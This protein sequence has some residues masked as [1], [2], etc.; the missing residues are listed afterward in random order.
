[1][2]RPYFS[3]IV[4]VYNKKEHLKKCLDSISN[5]SFKDFEIIIVDD[6]SNDGSDEIYSSFVWKQDVV[7]K[8]TENN[9][10]CI[11][12]NIGIS[13][14][15]GKWICFLDADDIYFSNHL[16]SHFDLIQRHS[17]YDIFATEQLIGGA[18]KPYINSKLNSELFELKLDDFIES[19]PISLNQVSINSKYIIDFPNERFPISEDW[20]YMRKF[21]LN[22]NMLKSNIITTDVVDHDDRTMNANDIGVIVEWNLYGADKISKEPKIPNKIARKIKVY[23][24]LLC[25]NMYLSNGEKKNGIKLLK[26]SFKFFPFNIKLLLLKGMTKYMVK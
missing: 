22:Y 2:D 26:E 23:T 14:S 3:V 1:M 6:G 24:V 12:R 15:K 9:G 8:R 13:L 19:N 18:K 7:I 5:Q 10:R 20:Y 25:A 17:A 21:H 16:Q 4:P 11:A